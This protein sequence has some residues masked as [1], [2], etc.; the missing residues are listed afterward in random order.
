MFVSCG[1]GGKNPIFVQARSAASLFGATKVVRV[2][3][4]C[5]RHR[6]SRICLLFFGKRG[7]FRKKF[8]EIGEFSE[9]LDPKRRFLVSVAPKWDLFSDGC[10]KMGSFLGWLRQNGINRPG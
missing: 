1:S 3:F 2:P 10:A 4:L 6:F 8:S 7:F 5:N 9:L